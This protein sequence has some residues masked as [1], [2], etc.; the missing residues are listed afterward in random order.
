MRVRF[1]GNFPPPYGGVTIKNQVLYKT[2]SEKVPIKRL[3]PHF[4]VPNCFYQAANILLALMPRQALVIGISSKGGKSKA[5][6]KL[7]YK[8]NRRTMNRSL[9]FM[10]GGTE[11]NRIIGNVN[12]IEWYRNY[13][14]I[15]AETESM[16]RVLKNAGLHNTEWFP[17][18]RNRY[19]YP[20]VWGKQQEKRLECVFFSNIEREKG[21]DLILEIAKETPNI[22]YYF[23]G[24][25]NQEYEM[26][27]FNA[28]DENENIIYKGIFKGN[29]TETYEELRRYDV[30]LL[31]TLWK[32]EGVPGILVEAKM[33]GLAIIVSNQSY[34][35]E[36][37]KNG[38][39]GL[40]LKEN[41]RED[42]LAAVERLDMDR[43]L[44]KLL[45]KNSY[46][47]SEK[48]CIERYINSIMDAL[49]NS[50][51]GIKVD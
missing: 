24:P 43:E 36:I 19:R 6:T 3:N 31:P 23:Y 11:A 39:E 18:C 14:K 20:P 2:L 30:L 41:T 21:V 47:S 5:L 28:V 22:D 26:N 34:N 1:I 25:I 45:K 48:F 46:A 50:G 40:V 13:K 44:L 9:Y 15:Y 51:G 38:I 4:F 17:N 33:A 35:A 16:V 27:F 42:L 10:M 49:K 37:V 12:E 32:T 29:N 7:L 8:F